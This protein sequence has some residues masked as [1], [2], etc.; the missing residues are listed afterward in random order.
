MGAR[1]TEPGEQQIRSAVPQ[2]L[3]PSGAQQA[4]SPRGGWVGIERNGHDTNA[5]RPPSQ[6]G[7]AANTPTVVFA[8]LGMGDTP[9][10]SR[11]NIN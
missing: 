9:T 5:K 6:R 11:P 4:A 10:E 2:P 1:G 8:S 7:A 3:G